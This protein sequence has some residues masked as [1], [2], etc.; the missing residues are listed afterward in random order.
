MQPADKVAARQ[1]R[2]PKHVATHPWVRKHPTV[3]YVISEDGA[4][5]FSVALKRQRSRQRKRPSRWR[6]F[7]V[8][9]SRDRKYRLPAVRSADEVMRE[10]DRNGL[11][12]TWTFELTS[13]GKR[14]LLRGT[15]ATSDGK[16]THQVIVPAHTELRTAFRSLGAYLIGER[17]GTAHQWAI[18]EVVSSRGPSKTRT[19]SGDRVT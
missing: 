10:A 4:H 8:G 12:G 1:G 17:T 14:I 5:A 2:A 19:R 15:I 18:D 3:R 7:F 13:D 6:I 11:R 9:P 16:M